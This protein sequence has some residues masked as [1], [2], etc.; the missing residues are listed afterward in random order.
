MSLFWVKVSY[1]IY[2]VCDLLSSIVDLRRVCGR[3]FFINFSDFKFYRKKNGP[4]RWKMKK[5]ESAFCWFFIFEKKQDFCFLSN[6][7]LT[8]G[9]TY[10]LLKV[11][12]S[13]LNLCIY[14]IKWYI[15]ADFAYLIWLV[16]LLQRKFSHNLLIIFVVI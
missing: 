12:W 9:K 11:K 2:L 16:F 14:S 5:K 4:E 3:I 6:K 7:F 10:C 8:Q 13:V 15:F 1:V